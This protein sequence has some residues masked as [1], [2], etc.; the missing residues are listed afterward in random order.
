MPGW[1]EHGK[2]DGGYWPEDPD[3]LDAMESRERYNKN[4]KL[5]EPREEAEPPTSS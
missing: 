3:A 2:W 5:N 1:R 4:W